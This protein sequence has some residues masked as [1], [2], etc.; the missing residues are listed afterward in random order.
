MVTH[1]RLAVQTQVQSYSGN[2]KCMLLGMGMIW[3]EFELDQV[4]RVHE[5]R[6]LQ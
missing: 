2:V 1:I 4:L 6:G 3:A 5:C